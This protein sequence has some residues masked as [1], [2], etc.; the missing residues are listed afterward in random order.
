[1]I[2]TRVLDRQKFGKFMCLLYRV[3]L[4]DREMRRFSDIPLKFF[5]KKMQTFLMLP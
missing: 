5:R 2:I 4:P 1:M 3:Y